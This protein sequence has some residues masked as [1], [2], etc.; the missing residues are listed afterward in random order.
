MERGRVNLMQSISVEEAKKIIQED[1]AAIFDIRDP[2]SFNTSHIKG[3]Q[4]LNNT[5]MQNMVAN[6]D[7]NLPVIVYCY[8]GISSVGAAQYLASQGFNKVYNIVGGYEAWQ[9]SA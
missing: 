6:T 1:N 3:A 2:E 7:K 4:N 5:T 9:R 8:H